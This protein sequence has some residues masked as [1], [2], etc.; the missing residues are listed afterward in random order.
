MR[1]ATVPE[2][3]PAGATSGVQIR[4]PSG[5]V[6]RV[7]S[8]DSPGPWNDA[9]ASFDDEPD[10]GLRDPQVR[11]A[12][13]DLLRVVL[14]RPP[15]RVADLGCGTGSLSRLLVDE[16]FSVDGVDFS[17]GMLERAQL[18]VP[19]ARFVLADA[20]EPALDPGTYDV[21]LSR[22]VL[23]A[24]RDPAA[25]FA[26]WV[27]LLKPG[28]IAVLIEGRWSTG[29]GLTADQAEQIVR[30]VCSTAELRMLPEPVYWGKRISDERYILVSWE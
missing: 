21:V 15:A 20:A 26:T 2:R 17:P 18:K 13:K 6:L 4:A 12:W 5:N 11:A 1:S 9:A 14:P 28:G 24:L 23:W 27:E 25:A 8:E 22:H 29:A 3:R 19:E 30:T 16:G 7:E 10:H